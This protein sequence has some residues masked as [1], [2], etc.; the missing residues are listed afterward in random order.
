M[1]SDFQ[2]A[3]AGAQIK[4][5]FTSKDRRIDLPEDLAPIV[6]PAELRRA[7][8]SQIINHLLQT[9]TPTP[10]AFLSNG[11]FIRSSIQDHL[12]Q[13]GLSIEQTLTLEAVYARLP[14]PHVSTF[15]HDDWISGVDVLSATSP[16]GQISD[17]AIVVGQERIITSSYDGILRIWDNNGKIVAASSSPKSA[18]LRSLKAI[19]YLNPSTVV[20]GGMD[21]VIRLCNIPSTSNP[22]E[23]D[24]DPPSASLNP[25]LALYGHTAPIESLSVSPSTS[26]ILSASADHTAKLWTPHQS[27]APP[28]SPSL[29]PSAYKRSAQRPPSDPCPTRGPLTTLPAHTG[30]VSGAIFKPSDPTVAYTSSWD[31]T[32]ATVDLTTSSLVTRRETSASLFALCAL[33]GLSLLAAGSAA[34]SVILVDV[35]AD[36]RDVAALTLRGH[37]NVV[38]AVAAE[39][40]GEGG[41]GLASGGHDG[42]VRIWDLRTVQQGKGGESSSLVLKRGEGN[43]EKVFAVCWDRTVGIVSAGEDKKVQVN[44]RE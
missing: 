41:W 21:R 19:R 5:Q 44:R 2:A 18:P 3:S 36:S 10:F 17:N 16:A 27:S 14:P 28:A 4:V 34:R 40:E 8:L 20:T 42:A 11:A 30:P 13:N 39:P 31:H 7:G 38:A 24:S 25:K 15:P 37:R 1:E 29:L 33:P 6:V 23:M 26:Q 32:I 12:S 43:G 9:P 35:R 22:D